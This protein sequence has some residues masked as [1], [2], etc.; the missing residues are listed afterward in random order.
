[1]IKSSGGKT[2]FETGAVRD[3][4]TAENGRCDLLPLDVISAFAP[5]SGGAREL[6]RYIA[7]FQE[8]GS[9]I[10]LHYALGIFLVNAEQ[11][12][13]WADMMLDVSIHYAEALEKYP[14]NND[15]R[16]DRA[17]VWNILGCLWTSVHMP[18]LNEYKK[19]EAEAE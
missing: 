6:L 11:Y 8:S 19:E 15:E 14:E 17:F 5:L 12:N 7:L 3:I 9:D 16:H 13:G 4:K 2:V 10:H 18:E 1:M